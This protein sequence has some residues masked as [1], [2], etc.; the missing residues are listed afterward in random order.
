MARNTKRGISFFFRVLLLLL[1]ISSFILISRTTSFEAHAA[2]SLPSWWAGTCDNGVLNGLQHNSGAKLDGIWEGLQS[3]SGGNH[4]YS[5]FG[6]QW[7]PG[8][9]APHQ[10]ECGIEEWQ[11]VE[12]AFRYIYFAFGQNV[13]SLGPAKNNPGGKDIVND[14]PEPGSPGSTGI[15]LQKVPNNNTQQQGPQK[16][17]VLSFGPYGNNLAG[18]TAIVTKGTPSGGTGYIT[19]FQENGGGLGAFFSRIHVTNYVVDNPGKFGL[20]LVINWLHDPSPTPTPTLSPTS[21]P[22]PTGQSVFIAGTGSEVYSLNAD[23]GSLQWSNQYQVGGNPINASTYPAPALANGILY[24]GR[25]GEYA[26]NS[27]TGQLLWGNDIGSDSI[28]SPTVVNGTL[29]VISENGSNAGYLEA[30]NSN[31]GTLLWSTS[32]PVDCNA[33]CNNDLIVSGSTIYISSDVGVYAVNS[34]NGSIIW[35]YQDQNLSDPNYF[36]SLANNVVYTSVSPQLFG[37]SYVSAFNASNGQLLWKYSLSSAIGGSPVIDNGVVYFGTSSPQDTLF[38]LNANTGNPVWQ[39]QM[40]G[41]I[42]SAPTAAN[43]I[44]YLNVGYDV[45]SIKESDGSTFWSQVTS[46]SAG[47]YSWPTVSNGLVYTIVYKPTKNPGIEI[48]IVY[49]MNI[50]TGYIQW[51]YSAKTMGSG[52]LLVGS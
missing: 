42:S 20:G 13:Y 47:Y 16:G 51:K 22:P 37:N 9:C 35:S 48:G 27:S 11:C 21:T 14:Y 41:P 30:Y 52:S 8:G 7:P 49:A 32:V 31:N 10:K 26:I 46:G 38:A 3:C 2:Y 18:H 39:D 15:Y 45:Y 23:N 25:D 5:T 34:G 50:Q 17:D 33:N 12:L 43:G 44:L 29:Y 6:G 24:V 36:I 40:S 28:T 4:Y 1:I 19:I